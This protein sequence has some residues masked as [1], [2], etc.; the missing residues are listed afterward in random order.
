M[1]CITKFPWSTLY[2]FRLTKHILQ[3]FLVVLPWWLSS[4]AARGLSHR[5]HKTGATTRT[6]CFKCASYATIPC[7]SNLK[8]SFTIGSAISIAEASF[9]QQMKWMFSSWLLCALGSPASIIAHTSNLFHF[10]ER[11][12][13][14]SS[15]YKTNG[16][17]TTGRLWALALNWWHD[18]KRFH[19]Y[20]YRCIIPVWFSIIHN[21]Y[22]MII[23][24]GLLLLSF[25]WFDLFHQQYPHQLFERADCRQHQWSDCKQWL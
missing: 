13:L 25:L 10:L 7:V 6:S 3:N 23:L 16:T 8:R 19:S 22:G 17:I 4:S 2:T 15:E 12:P 5:V 21:Y 20:R 11:L 9:E 1:S 24:F 18:T 14:V